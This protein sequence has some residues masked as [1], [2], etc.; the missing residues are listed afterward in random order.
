MGLISFERRIF[1]QN[2]NLSFLFLVDWQLDCFHSFTHCYMVTATLTWNFLALQA[3]TSNGTNHIIE[4]QWQNHMHLALGFRSFTGRSQFFT[5]AMLWTIIIKVRS[6]LCNSLRFTRL[7]AT[8]ARNH[9][10][11]SES[12]LLLSRGKWYAFSE[13]KQNVANIP[14]HSALNHVTARTQRLVGRR[15]VSAV[16]LNAGAVECSAAKGTSTCLNVTWPL[17]SL[18]SYG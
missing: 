15:F 17:L 14:C 9:N 10:M 3:F 1:F 18:L 12:V 13:R 2:R 4:Q 11:L 7:T 16:L 5:S 6:W 8:L